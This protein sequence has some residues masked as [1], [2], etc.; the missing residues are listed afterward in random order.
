MGLLFDLHRVAAARYRA[1]RRLAPGLDVLYWV[2]SA[3]LVFGVLLAVNHGQLRVFVFL[4]L[5]IGV[6]G[7]FGLLSPAV[8]RL[9]TLLLEAAGGTVRALRRG[10]AMLVL[11]PSGW[12]VRA[13]AQL[14]DVAFLLILALV[15][16]LA[17]LALWP[18]KPLLRRLGRVVFPALKKLVPPGR[19]A[20]VGRAFRRLGERVSRLLIWLGLK[21]GGRGPG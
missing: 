11:R 10:L 18:V 19:F 2:V 12:L 3:L 21:S 6:T 1:V 4:G 8:V 14:T 7:Y 16:G 13:L 17:R 20:P 5:G 9:V 15:V